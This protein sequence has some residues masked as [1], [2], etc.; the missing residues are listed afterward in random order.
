MDDVDAV[1]AQIAVNML[2]SGHW[3]TARLDGV[4]YLEK[5]PLIYWMMAGSFKL[6]GVHTWSARVP[7]VF[8]AIA[9]C[10]VTAWFGI[11]AF[12]ER[13]A[14]LF[15]GLCMATC[16]GLWLFTRIEI[17]NVTLVLTITLSMWAFL[18]LLED[19]V[20]HP[21]WWA[22]LIGACFGT[23]LLLES[24]IAV[25]FPIGA[26]I[27]YFALTKRLFRW[28]SWKRLHPLLVTVVMLAVAAPWHILATIRNPPYF[29]FTMK[30]V[31]GQWHGFF[32][33]FFINEQLLR[34]LNLRYPRD[35]S[36]VPRY[37]FWL[38]NLIWLF[39]WSV[40]L[41]GTFKLSY[42]P[43]DRAGRTRLLALCWIGF[44]MVFFTFSTTQEYYSMPI[45][46]AV[47]LL[48]GSAMLVES[49]AKRWGTRVLAVI[50][51]VCAIAAIGLL[52][53][54]R[55]V[56]TPGDISHDLTVRK[57]YRLS[58]DHMLDL[59][60]DAFAYLR[61]PLALAA[62]AFV[63]GAA[64]TLRAKWKRSY[65]GVALMMV[66]FFQAAHAA[67]ARFDP[68][69]SSRPLIRTLKASPPG[70]L[71]IDH[72]YYYFSS[73]FFYTDRKA[74]MLNGRYLNLVYGSYSPR[75][76]DPFIDNSQFEAMWKQPQR[77]YML[78]RKSQYAQLD[79]LVGRSDLFVVDRAGDKTLFTNH[80][81]P[82]RTPEFHR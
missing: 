52:I 7:V 77:W 58:L 46:P 35:Y 41:P 82:G 66:V 16:V 45:Y 21:R 27:V 81:I 44:V 29:D 12:G 4:P 10:L 61:L 3:V 62:A 36:T 54:V 70:K 57:T 5:P 11:W 59:R 51:V 67:M 79:S 13:R 20:R 23:G 43:V 34:F 78:A 9:L 49:R 28:E 37:L 24:L 19:D 15:A 64:S 2:Q 63:I 22:A 32:W 75:S 69:L 6:F 39:P 1:Q 31:P 72:H 73:L 71:M 14:G 26:W 42:K 65:L 47:A 74:L 40:Y 33:F 50:C 68:Y 76:E 55:H 8:S 30:S 25:V 80:P 18:R 56:P 38:F 48:L 53:A 17:P 60:L